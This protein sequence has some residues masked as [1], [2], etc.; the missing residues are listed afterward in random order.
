MTAATEG[1][2][3]GDDAPVR[4]LLDVDDLDADELTALLDAAAA[5]GRSR[6]PPPSRALVGRSVV[7]LFEQPSTRTRVSFERAV[8]DL[9]GD[10][11]FM[12]PGETQLS[13]GEP[14]RDT[15]RCLA[16]YTDAIVARVE[17]HESLTELATYADVPVVNA[18][19]DRAHPC[20]TLADLLTVR[21]VAGD[22]DGATAAWVGDG[23]N[24]ARSFALGCA[25][26]GVDLTVATPPEHGLDDA[27]LDRA[28]ALGDA[29][30]VAHDPET[31]VAGAD[32]VYTDAWVSMNHSDRAERPATFETGGFQ[33]DASLLP[34]DAAFMHC[35]PAHRGAEVT[36]AVV[37]SDRSVVWRQ[38]ENRRHA[39]TALL[40]RLLAADSPPGP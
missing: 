20:Q 34:A 15:A 6:D 3:D 8:T 36:D 35:L 23:N 22:L 31:A 16:G 19:S 29:P 28:A 37:E 18:L 24:V 40:E 33:V 11:V 10:T 21:E 9:G 13:R 25:A 17:D 2:D 30:T 26:T 5:F 14:L 27:T 7:L 1:Q 38:A 4:H 32:V 39:Q 12:G